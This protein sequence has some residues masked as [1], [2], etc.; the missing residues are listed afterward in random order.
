M[1]LCIGLGFKSG[2]APPPPTLTFNVPSLFAFLVFVFVFCWPFTKLNFGWKFFCKTF[3]IVE[4][5]RTS[6]YLEF[7][8]QIFMLFFVC[9]SLVC[10]TVSCPFGFGL[11]DLFPLLKSD[12]SQR[13][14]LPLKMMSQAV[15]GMW[16]CMGGC[17]QFKGES[18]KEKSKA[19]VKGTSPWLE[20][21]SYTQ[22]WLWHLNMSWDINIVF[23]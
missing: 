3:R 1:L 17:R 7:S 10:L 6:F 20:Q 11:K 19:A 15:Q 21:M 8:G 14:L 18:V 13:C 22:C 23:L 9:F 2:I 5:S 12:R 4:L 16:V